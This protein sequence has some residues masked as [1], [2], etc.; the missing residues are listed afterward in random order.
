MLTASRY[1]FSRGQKLAASYVNSTGQTKQGWGRQ[2]F[3]P[4]SLGAASHPSLISLCV[5]LWALSMITNSHN[6][7]AVSLIFIQRLICADITWLCQSALCTRRSPECSICCCWSTRVRLLRSFVCS[8]RGG[9]SFGLSGQGAVALPPAIAP[10]G[11]HTAYSSRLSK[12][13]L[14]PAF[15]HQIL[16]VEVNTKQPRSSKRGLRFLLAR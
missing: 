8:S 1:E 11:M 15:H 12:R 6:A 3:T 14:H 13:L 5:N 9:D 16:I 7:R 4:W 10:Y 2:T